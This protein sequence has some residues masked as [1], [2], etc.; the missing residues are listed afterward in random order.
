MDGV[1]KSLLP[2]LFFTLG[3]SAS[4]ARHCS[5]G[6]KGPFAG[7]GEKRQKGSIKMNLGE[8]PR[9]GALSFLYVDMGTLK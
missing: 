8:G 9:E 5:T 1:R 3:T 2:A 4:F 6:G 7:G